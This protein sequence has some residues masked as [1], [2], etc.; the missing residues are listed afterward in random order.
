MKK[1]LVIIGLLFG[2]GAFAQDHFS[3]ISTSN[4]VGIL[5]GALNPAEFSNLSKKF[6]INFFGLSLDVANNKVGISDLG[7]DNLEELIFAGNEPVNMRF[8]GQIMGP[9]FAMKWMLNLI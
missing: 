9:G 2:F 4:R 3:G 8:D 6:E 5:N 7:S 1:T